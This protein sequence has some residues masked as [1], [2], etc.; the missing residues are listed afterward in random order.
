VDLFEGGAE[1]VLLGLGWPSK[2][3][4]KGPIIGRERALPRSSSDHDP[5]T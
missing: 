4:P 5:A 1:V 2:D 3:E